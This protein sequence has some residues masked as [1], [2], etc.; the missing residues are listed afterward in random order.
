MSATDGV[1]VRGLAETLGSVART[2]QAEPDVDTTLRAIVK[3]AVDHVPGA[4]HAGISLVE[5]GRIRTVA[6]TSGIVETIEQLQYDLR[7]GPCIDA[8]AEHQ[9][10]RVG[11]VGDETRWPVFGPAAA[12]NGIHSLL[13]YRLFVTDRTLGA[14]NL[15]SSRVDA[16]D[17]HTEEDGRLFATH[18]AIALIGAQREARLAIAVENRDVISTAKGILMERHDIDATSA[19]RMLV[20][21]SQSANVKLHLAAAWLVENRGVRRPGSRAEDLSRGHPRA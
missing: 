8:I 13:S 19:F 6:P 18:A 10:Y 3:A 14:L 4:E 5:R 11:N 21:T 9:T 15:Y 17:L 1:G 16:F 20:E 12:E 2:L 7:Q